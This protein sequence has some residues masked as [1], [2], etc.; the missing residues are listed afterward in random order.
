MILNTLT[1]TNFKRFKNE[2]IEFPDGITGITGENGAGKSSIVEG[3]VFALFG[4]QG[5]CVDSDFILSSAA[6]PKDK[7]EVKLEFSVDGEDYT[8]IR[9]FKKAK[10]IHHEATLY[11]NEIEIANSVSAVADEVSR[12][13]GMSAIDLQ[14]TVYAGQGDL[15]SIINATPSVRKDWFMKVVGIDSI[16]K[17]GNETLREQISTL[18]GEIKG[19]TG[20]LQQMDGDNIG[21]QIAAGRK[22]RDEQVELCR[23]ATL[24]FQTLEAK[25]KG[26]QERKD[27]M[28]PH[29]EDFERLENQIKQLEADLNATTTSCTSVSERVDRLATDIG[30]I[31]G[32]K[33]Q[34]D[35]YLEIQTLLG[36]IEV[37]KKRITSLTEDIRRRQDRVKA[38]TDETAKIREILSKKGEVTEEIND[39]NEQKQVFSQ[40]R[41]ELTGLTPIIEDLKIQSEQRAYYQ[42]L[43]KS[44]KDRVGVDLPRPDPI[45]LGY[46]VITEG[47][48]DLMQGLLDTARANYNGFLAIR[49]TLEKEI[50]ALEEKLEKVHEV[51]EAGECP[52]C[53]QKVGENYQT[54][55]ASLEGEIDEKVATL[56]K[57]GVEAGKI[58]DDIGLYNLKI[59]DINQFLED[60]KQYTEYLQAKEELKSISETLEEIDA[61]MRDLIPLKER[62]DQIVTDLKNEERINARL[63]EL[64]TQLSKINT[65]DEA[66]RRNDRDVQEEERI[67]PD[68]TAEMQTNITTAK[69]GEAL[70]IEREALKNPYEQYLTLTG[71]VT[72]LES[73]DK[74]LQELLERK[75]TYLSQIVE[76]DKA[77][78]THQYNPIA[79]KEAEEEYLSVYEATHKMSGEITGLESAAEYWR[80]ELGRLDEALKAIT[81]LGEKKQAAEDELAITK[82][83]RNAL[84]GF[85]EN[86]LTLIRENIKEEADQ[87]I[88]EVT[89]G[90]Y[91][92]IQISD[93]FDLLVEDITGV[94]PVQRFSGGEQDVIAVALRIA[95]SRF[96]ANL[97]QIRDS[98]FLIFDEI[99]GSQDTER[100]LNLLRAMRSQEN[101]FPQI[102]LISHIPDIQDE[103]ENLIEVSRVSDK[104]SKVTI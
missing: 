79:W 54:I 60:E 100:R 57:K 72:L 93:N 84:N 81:E 20:V 10:S 32:M 61:G 53:T 62:Y 3:V 67:I 68:L 104:Y 37:A 30:T 99:F 14:H 58:Q 65:A 11:H 98:T 73:L 35:R 13:I 27:L 21:E 29:K 64:S 82:I 94:Y 6:N 59:K 42:G 18:E 38:I 5:T 80:K 2:V 91:T 49:P 86:L 24:Q 16:K 34:H 8:V 70:E 51:G 9:T 1:L 44:T 31:K 19:L 77:M 33:P 25:L 95:V 50:A 15:R 7:C 76:T 92:G 12:I 23:V 4:V 52:Y 83:V 41:D 90:R 101:R 55:V 48:R 102:L 88:S 71:K 26:I 17:Y 39:L 28:S 22:A 40:L 45:N 75:K 66:I 97:N 43:I 63:L 78:Q 69:A 74:E 85:L 89:N 96:I 46:E 103:F 56:E 87:I 36:D 47:T